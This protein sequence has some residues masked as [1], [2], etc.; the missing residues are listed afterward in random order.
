LFFFGGACSRYIVEL[1]GGW[2]LLTGLGA[3]ALFAAPS[4]RRGAGLLRWIATLAAVWSVAAVWLCSFEFR[5]FA[6]VTQP[7]TYSTL[8]ETLNLPSF[9][10]AEQIGHKFGPLA[11][12]LIV[13]TTLP[14][15]TPSS[16][17]RA[18]PRYSTHSSSN[19]PRRNASVFA[20][21][22]TI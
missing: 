20:S 13:P 15:A 10:W 11:F 16:S 7:A 19:G 5:R 1:L 9:W 17:P 12:D 3:L 14:P 6:R 2:T 22:S 18:V 8:A 21:C 4:N